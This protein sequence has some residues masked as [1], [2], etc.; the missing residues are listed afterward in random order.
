MSLQKIKLPNANDDSAK[1]KKLSKS[2]A[3]K[4]Q[5]ARR[6]RWL[7]TGQSVASVCRNLVALMQTLRQFQEADAA[8]Q[9][10]LLRMNSTKFVGTMLL[11]KCSSTSS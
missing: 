3:V 7:S 2:L 9:G 11:K 6:T 8:A 1:K 4:I 5:R 10:L